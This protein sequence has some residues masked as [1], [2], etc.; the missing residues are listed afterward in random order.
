MMGVQKIVKY[1]KLFMKQQ[2]MKWY[3]MVILSEDRTNLDPELLYNQL[4]A[5]GEL[6][7]YLKVISQLHVPDIPKCTKHHHNLIN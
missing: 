5:L 1:L 7:T 6:N 2:T 4:F 3:H